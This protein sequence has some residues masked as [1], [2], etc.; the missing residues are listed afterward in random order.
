MQ[1]EKKGF[2]IKMDLVVV[3]VFV[4]VRGFPKQVFRRT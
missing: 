3:F 1:G 2:K 4:W